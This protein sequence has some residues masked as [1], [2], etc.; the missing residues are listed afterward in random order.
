MV[1]L[2]LDLLS[3]YKKTLLEALHCAAQLCMLSILMLLVTGISTVVVL[4]KD[5]LSTE[6]FIQNN[7]SAAGVNQ[8]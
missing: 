5:Y 1:V 6:Y 4:R 8:H 3:H 2:F 7:N